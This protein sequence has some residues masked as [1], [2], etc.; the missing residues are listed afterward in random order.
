MAPI[1]KGDGTPLELPGV[2]EVRSGD[3]R[4][5]FDAIPD[6]VV[7]R[8]NDDDST[9]RTEKEGL[10]IEVKSDWPSIGVEISNN[11]SGASTAYLQD[12]N[13]NEIQTTDISELSSG[14]A[15]TFD[16]VNLQSGN[17]Y[18][19]LL[20]DGGNSWTLGFTSGGLDYPYTSDDV[21]ITATVEN[22]DEVTT[23]DV[24]RAV[25]NIGN[26]GFN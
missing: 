17:K 12:S 14:D 2:S 18:R 6:S 22:D 13:G 24:V 26:V 11:S 3:G 15:F 16:E 20:D 9:T 10:E 1:R 23:S 25:D 5:F 21:D 7:S 4:V 8:P 19:I